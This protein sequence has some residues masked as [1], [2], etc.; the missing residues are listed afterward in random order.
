MKK[1]IKI[2]RISLI[3]IAI[4]LTLGLCSN[5]I[6]ISIKFESPIDFF[7]ERIFYYIYF[8]GDI[9][10]FCLLILV[11]FLR[12]KYLWLACVLVVAVKF[13]L[14]L[15]FFLFSPYDSYSIYYNRHFASLFDS[16]D[17]YVIGFVLF[18]NNLISFSLFCLLYITLIYLYAKIIKQLIRYR[19]DSF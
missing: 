5:V 8:I 1:E 6:R 18:G 16:F 2:L 7:R 19:L 9:V 13:F 14:L 15:K 10:L 17:L 12:N 3:V 11:T 4:V